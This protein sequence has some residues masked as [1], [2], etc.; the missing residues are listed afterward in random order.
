MISLLHD[1]LK[2]FS[3]S[4]SF[5]QRLTCLQE[6]RS[7]GIWSPKRHSVMAP[8][9]SSQATQ[10]EGRDG[11]QITKSH[12]TAPSA[13]VSTAVGCGDRVCGYLEAY[14]DRCFFRLER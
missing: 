6:D 5:G 8:P 1:V 11:T 7:T 14:N 4:V 13:R 10:S 9:K 2:R 12:G 3:I